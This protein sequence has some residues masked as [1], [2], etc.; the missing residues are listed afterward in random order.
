MEGCNLTA[1]FGLEMRV[2][3]FSDGVKRLKKEG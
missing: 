1:I 3:V 2:A